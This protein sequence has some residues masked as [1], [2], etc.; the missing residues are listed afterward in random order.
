MGDFYQNG[1]VCTLHNL[2]KRTVESLEE[3]LNSFKQTR[4]MALILPSLFS[5]LEGPALKHI[6]D[7]LSHA[8][9]IDEIVIGLD[10][11]TEDQYRYALKFFDKL[12][13]KHYVLW[14]DGPA[15]SGIM[16]E[17]EDLDLAPKQAGKGKN[18]WTCMGYALA[19]CKAEAIG[20]H[21]CDI[22][23]YERGML[24]RL[25]YPVANPALDFVFCKGFYSRIADQKMN[26]R[27]CRLFVGPLLNALRKVFGDEEY[28][29]YMNSFRYA[30][31]GE[32]SFRRDVLN[33]IRIPSDWGLEVGM[34]SEMY[35][36]YANN[37][38]CQADIADAYDHKHQDLSADDANT[39]LS[40]M[41]IDIA[42][43]FFRKLAT[44]GTVFN[45]GSFR[46][47]K[48]TYYRTALDYID[49]YQADAIANN[50][51]YDVHKEEASVELF[52]ENIM[53]AGEIFLQRP[54]ETPFIPCWQRIRTAIPDIFERL[55]LAVEQDQEKYS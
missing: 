16:S 50:L 5:E 54:M 37:R 6:V 47:L 26:G 24:A 53:N 20:L 55:S 12:P 14:N 44:Q 7:E 34:L 27:V 39:G 25:M 4:P 36:N 49:F 40:K 51:K 42:K 23:T 19:S 28:L 41:S 22:L 11:A 31:A 52:A 45:S 9:Y 30:L 1:Y 43:A 8:T 29:R 18:V 21:D 13:Q 17:L 3:D 38:V 10:R 32:F 33:T 2:T 35:R 15:L 48:A 46:T